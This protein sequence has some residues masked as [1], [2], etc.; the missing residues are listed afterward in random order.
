LQSDFRVSVVD[1]VQ[2][3]MYSPCAVCLTAGSTS[4]VYADAHAVAPAVL[5]EAAPLLSPRAAEAVASY[6]GE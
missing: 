3:I 6:T 5:H 2:T 4:D 1:D